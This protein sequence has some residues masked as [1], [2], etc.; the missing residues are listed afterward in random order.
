LDS[1]TSTRSP[2]VARARAL[3]T[4]AG[5]RETGLFIVEGPDGVA[6]AIAAGICEEI[7][8]TKSGARLLSAIP[9]VTMSERV[10]GV[11]SE[12]ETPRGVLAICRQPRIELEELCSRPGPLVWA[13]GV[14]DP[15]N[16]GTI[17]RTVW[18]LGAAGVVTS[19]HSVDA[20]NSKVVRASA[21]AICTVPV[22]P[23]AP[24]PDVVSAL[25][26][27]ARAIVVLAGEANGDVF[28]MLR[29]SVID[30]RACWVVGSES[31]GVCADIRA[32]AR[33]QVCLP[34]PGGAESL[35]A[36]VATSVA[37]YATWDHTGPW[38]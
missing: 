3:T 22:V 9:D 4:R 26:A 13:D 33:R 17:I 8:A 24:I 12:T 25:D 7:W 30:Q 37:L 27:S 2:R 36:G 28:A 31:H 5:R 10:S 21:G 29:D 15:G 35:N 11:V 38:S 1:I 20:F 34:L 23:D 18:A 19:N 32:R 6:A 14:S 16:L